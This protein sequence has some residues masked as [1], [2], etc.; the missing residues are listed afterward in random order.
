M[1]DEPGKKPDEKDPGKKVVTTDQLLEM[2][3]KQ[4]ELMQAL[5]DDNSQ[6]IQDIVTQV[7]EKYGEQSEQMKNITNLLG[8]L[9]TGDEEIDEYTGERKK[10][11]GIDFDGMTEDKFKNL[12][13]TTIQADKKLDA[14]ARKESGKRQGDDYAKT[15]QRSLNTRRDPEG[16]LLDDKARKDITTLLKTKI[17][18]ISSNDGVEAALIN[19]E[20]AYSIIYDL[21]KENPFKGNEDV[22][23]LGVG[24]PGAGPGEKKETVKLTKTTEAF[25]ANTKNLGI[26]REEAKGYIER[27]NKRLAETE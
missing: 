17:L 3:T 8:Q 21:N 20:K 6:A 2:V 22:S 15:V 10:K 13:N 12:V 11:G 18:D 7:N 24:A 4:N 1:V 14:E 27:R 5:K 9:A 16:K 23:G 25:L 26:S 19:F